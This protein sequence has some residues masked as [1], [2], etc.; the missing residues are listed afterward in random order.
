M[1]GNVAGLAGHL[2]R[3]L[4]RVVTDAVLGGLRSFPRRV[5]D[6]DETVLSR[7]LGRTVTS[8]SVLDGDA[9]TSSRARLKLTGDGVP[10]SVFVKMPAE[11]AA[12]RLMGELGR[13]AHTEV[14]F[15]SQLSPLLSGVPA[16]HGSAF[17]PLTGRYVLVLE[18]LAVD[19][20]DFPDTL[21]PLDTDRAGLIV[22]LLARLHAT[23]WERPPGWV[24]S[25][26]GDHTS[27]LTGPLLKVSARRLAERTSIPVHSGRFIDDNYRAVAQLIDTPPHTVMHGD[28]HPGNVYF[29]N[30]E[31]GLLDWQAVR[32]GHPS[33]E[34]S[35]S[36]ITGMTTS[37]RQAAERDLLDEYR[38]ALAAAGGPRLDRDELWERYRTAA[39]YAYVASVITAGMGGMQAEGVALEGVRRA[40]AA[41]EDLDTVALLEKS[42]SG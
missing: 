17:D 30:G 36:L 20:C 25:A 9:G 14:R 19:R 13:L 3:G 31:A 35:Y 34:L 16:C 33:R 1:A 27:L 37:D 42:L 12:T 39:L 32:R 15:Y 21:H 40:V 8:V 22:E 26:S 6:L 2:G 28:A 38:R 5:A 41:L 7:L 11:T 10:A 23:F 4:Q 29:R 18:D 24:Y